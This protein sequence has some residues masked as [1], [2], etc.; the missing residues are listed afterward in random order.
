MPWFGRLYRRDRAKALATVIEEIERCEG[1]VQRTAFALS[2]ERRYFYKVIHRDSDTLWPAIDRARQ[3]AHE[4][5][6]RKR[7]MLNPE[8]P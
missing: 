7:R 5:A 4:R 8:T 6:E 2:L 3:R 1:D